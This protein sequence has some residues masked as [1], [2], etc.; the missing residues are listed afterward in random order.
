MYKQ[1]IKISLHNQ[2][3]EGTKGA[4]SLSAWLFFHRADE[5]L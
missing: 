5:L 2:S 4:L 3:K 1:F